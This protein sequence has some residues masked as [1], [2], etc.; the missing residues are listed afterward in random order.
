MDVDLIAEL[1]S[2]APMTVLL[3]TW[4]LDEE[5][6]IRW[7]DGGFVRWDGELYRALTD[8][9]V[10]NRTD[11]IVDGIDNEVTACTIEVM[12]ADQDAHDAMTAYSVQGSRITQHLG[13]VDF[14]TGLLIGE[15]DLLLTSEVDDHSLGSAA[16]AIAIHTITEE[17]R[18]LEA[19]DQRRATDA[20][21]QSIYPGELGYSN[22]TTLRRKRYWRLDNP[23]NA[24]R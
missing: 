5:T 19:D 9:G 2:Q 23:N 10:I 15:P 18:M 12:P 22:K 7:T 6:T 17:A 1:A 16:G 4:E 8:Y 13:V 24:I 20:F 14:A 21:H 11:E 3:Y